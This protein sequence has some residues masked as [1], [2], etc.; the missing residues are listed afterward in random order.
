MT[1]YYGWYANRV[2]GTRKKLA[3]EASQLLDKAVLISNVLTGVDPNSYPL[4]VDPN[5]YPS[6]ST[7]TAPSSWLGSYRVNR[8]R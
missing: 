4:S 8:K 2:R 1:R 5:S 3:G 7:Q 6:A